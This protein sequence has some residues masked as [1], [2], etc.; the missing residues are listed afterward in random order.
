MK[1]HIEIW[2]IMVNNACYIKC[3]KKN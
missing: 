2:F 3:K 1:N